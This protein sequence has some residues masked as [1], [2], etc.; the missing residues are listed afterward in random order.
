MPYNSVLFCIISFFLLYIETYSY[1]MLRIK[2]FFPNFG[3]HM[4]FPVFP[5]SQKYPHY[6]RKAFFRA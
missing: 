2:W 1:C 4:D 5:P 6:R 3:G